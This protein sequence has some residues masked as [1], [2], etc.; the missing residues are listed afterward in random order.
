VT[1]HD[2]L[3]RAIAENPAED[4]PRLVFA[5][6][7][8]EHADAFPN[9][10]AARARAAFIRADVEMAQR[11]GNDPVRLRW[12]LIEKPPREAE[13][14]VKAAL[15][16][17]PGTCEFVRAPLLRRGFP[18]A[19]VL[20]AHPLSMLPEL[21]VGS[22]P[23]E[24]VCYDG[25][26]YSGFDQLRAAAW[27]ARLRSIE[28]ERGGIPSAQFRRFFAQDGFERLERLAFTGQAIG[29]PGVRELVALPLFGRLTALVVRGAQ[30]GAVIGAALA[31]AGRCGLR[32]L[33]LVACRLS[34]PA[35]EAL[36]ASPAARHLESLAVGGDRIAAP[37]KFRALGQAH[38]PPPLRTLDV[39]DDAPNYAGLAEFVASPLVPHLVR[40]N[41]TRCNLNTD[42]TRLLATGAFGSLRVLVL[43]GN[44]VGNG[45]ASALASSPHL[46]GLRV[47][48]LGYSQVGDEGIAAILESPLADGLVL[49]NLVGSPASAEMKDVLKARMGDCVRV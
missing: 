23:L 43:S 16:V 35:L 34:G 18:W 10:A 17:L 39:S 27:R 9:P 13:G 26:G 48:D 38:D 44:Q 1:D 21:P 49:L 29:P 3:L 19:V 22:F 12:E 25:D 4:T 5:D 30:M 33:Q 45:G 6:W 15:P 36:L 37:E 31:G 8:D 7:L 24:Q 11:D 46:A 32:E 20:R 42:R 47:L 28:F 2:A 40:L 41:L 14:W